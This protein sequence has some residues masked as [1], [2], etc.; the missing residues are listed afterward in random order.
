MDSEGCNIPED[1]EGCNFPET[2]RGIHYPTHLSQ[3]M[4][5]ELLR[6]FQL[7]D[8]FNNFSFILRNFVSENI[9]HKFKLNNI[10]VVAINHS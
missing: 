6:K 9:I 5:T 8:N 4:N 2:D 3:V 10:A 1:S 7:T